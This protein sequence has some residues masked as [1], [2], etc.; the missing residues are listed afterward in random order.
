MTN[1]IDTTIRRYTSGMGFGYSATCGAKMVLILATKLQ[2]PID[3][4]LF[5]YGNIESSQNDARYV[6]WKSMLMEIFVKR[7]NMGIIILKWYS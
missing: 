4:A 5:K 2:M 6:I 3:V 1:A 7:M